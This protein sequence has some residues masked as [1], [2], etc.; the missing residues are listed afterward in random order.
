V[1]VVLGAVVL[2]ALPPFVPTGVRPTLMALFDPLCHQL[3][4]RS[5]AVEGVAFALCHRCSGI[6][7][8][9]A[10]GL[11]VAPLLRAALPRDDGKHGLR[12]L[13]LAA[14]PM[15]TDWAL[16]VLGVWMNTPASRFGTGAVFG[17]C[18][19]LVLA[20]ALAARRP[21]DAVD[22]VSRTA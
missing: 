14:L 6:A 11:L 15:G 13:A 7:L 22:G 2:A 8:G 1:G 4:A 20:R 17:V 21:R 9:L 5:F 12:L 3:P 19:G 16:D 10:A 18:A